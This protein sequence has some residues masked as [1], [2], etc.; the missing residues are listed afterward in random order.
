MASAF[1]TALIND[2]PDLLKFLDPMI[3]GMCGKSIFSAQHNDKCCQS[4]EMYTD[5]DMP[6]AIPM[7]EEGLEYCNG[8]FRLERDCECFDNEFDF[9]S[10][11]D[12]F[13]PLP[14]ADE[15]PRN[16]FRRW[17]QNTPRIWDYDR[18]CGRE[19]ERTWKRQVRAVKLWARH[20]R[21]IAKNVKS[22]DLE[23]YDFIEWVNQE[24]REGQRMDFIANNVVRRRR[25]WFV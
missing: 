9:C 21:R 25:C 13:D 2:S 5:A 7:S 22:L 8:C 24:F 6:N 4:M 23:A 19:R 16:F 17:R 3:C 14:E 1:I 12:D 11:T 15:L 18:D 10:D 20:A